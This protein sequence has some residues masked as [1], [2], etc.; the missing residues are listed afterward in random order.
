MS[1]F[2]KK[3]TGRYISFKRN[4]E[5]KPWLIKVVLPD[6]E[7]VQE[8]DRDKAIDIAE[9]QWLDLVLISLNTKPPL[10]KIIDYWQYLYEQK[11]KDNI[12]NKK[13]KGETK[14]I[15]LTFNIWQHDFEVKLKQAREFIEEKHSVRI[16]LQF[17]WR[18]LSHKSLWIEKVTRF[19]E[20]LQD[21][22]KVEK[23]PQLQWKQ[24]ISLLTPTKK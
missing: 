9:S 11:K 19:I 18:E 20:A 6:W 16:C 15:R 5:I 8:M 10:C 17:K 1:K 2:R 12:K 21:V 14:W 13:E 22:S 7:W 24:I 3:A 4:R 23:E